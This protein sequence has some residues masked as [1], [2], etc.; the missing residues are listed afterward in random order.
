MPS[1]QQ[2]IA[3]K[4]TDEIFIFFGDTIID[5]DIQKVLNE[6]NSCFCVKKVDDP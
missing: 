1:G 4:D 3:I 2:E 6:P 5:F